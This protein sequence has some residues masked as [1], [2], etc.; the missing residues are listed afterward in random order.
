MN[1]PHCASDTQAELNAEVNIHFTGFRNNVDS[2]GLLIFP[3]LLVCLDC[4]FSRFTTPEDELALLAMCSAKS[5]ASPRKGE[6]RN[7][8]LCRSTAA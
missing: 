3:K 6:V 1:C 8:A 7:V 5:D 2:P 4:G